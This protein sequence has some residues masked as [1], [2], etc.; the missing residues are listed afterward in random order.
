MGRTRLAARA[1]FHVTGGVFIEANPPDGAEALSELRHVGAPPLGHRD[2]ADQ[3]AW[4]VRDGV[5]LARGEAAR[6]DPELTR[7][8]P[9]LALADKGIRI[10]SLHNRARRNLKV[11]YF[12]P[13]F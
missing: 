2:V 4:H 5:V 11:Y 10:S 7:P 6:G 3:H 13:Y 9:L 1:R 12:F 8:R